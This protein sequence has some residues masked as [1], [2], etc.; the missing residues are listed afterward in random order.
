[1]LQRC[2]ALLAGGKDFENGSEEAFVALRRGLMAC[3]RAPP[4]GAG[5]ESAG[6]AA[7][8]TLDTLPGKADAWA[9]LLLVGEK[10][11]FYKAQVAETARRLEQSPAWAA[12]LAADPE[13]T[14]KRQLLA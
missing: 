14:R 11:R 10:H 9:F 6:P 3:P 4:E 13:L 7:A 12:A 2:P 1:M 8:V 5:L